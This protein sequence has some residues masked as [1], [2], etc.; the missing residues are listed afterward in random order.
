MFKYFQTLIFLVSCHILVAQNGDKFLLLNGPNWEFRKSGDSIWLPAN[1]PGTVHTDLMTLGLIPDPFVGNNEEKVQ[2]VENEGW[3]YRTSFNLEQNDIENFNI[4]LILEGLDTY[5]DV[6]VNDCLVLKA[7]NMFRSFEIDVKKHLNSGKNRL[8]IHFY[9]ASKHGKGEALKLPYSLPSDERIFCRKAQY[10]FGW[11]WGPRLV[12]CG[13]W[14]PVKLRFVRFAYIEHLSYTQN[15]INDTLVQLNLIA[16][17]KSFERLNDIQLIVKIDSPAINKLNIVKTSLDTGRRRIST[18]ILLPNPRKWWCNGLGEPFMYSV[19]F[20]LFKAYQELDI[21]NINIGIRTLDLVREKDSLGE[22]F[23]FKLNGIKV[24]AKGANVIPF[25][26]FLPR[27]KEGTY[28]KMVQNAVDA[29]MNMLRVWGGGVYGEDEFYDACDKQGIMVWQDFMFANSMYPST[30]ILNEKVREE[31]KSQI[32]RLRNHPSLALWCGNNE[33]IEGWN[34]WGWQKQYGYSS[35]DSAEIY[36]NYL[37]F[38]EDVLPYYILKMDPLRAKN[39]WPS[40]PSIG[41]GRKESLLKGDVHYW[42]V[43]WG[44]QPFEMYEKKVGRFVSEYGFQS[45]PALSTFQKVITDS[46]L[47]LNSQEVKSHQKHPTGYQTIQTYME[48]DYKVPTLFEDYIYVSQ[49]LQARGMKIAIEAHRRNK[50]Y[51]MGTL[52]WQMN[53]CWP[54]T[55]WSSIDYYGNLKASHYQVKRSFAQSLLS[56]KDADTAIEVYS[57][58]DGRV[59]KI[60]VLTIEVMDFKGKMLWQRILNVAIKPDSGQKQ[61]ILSKSIFKNLDTSFVFVLAK[62]KEVNKTDSLQA[63]YFLVKPKNLLLQKPAFLL[64]KINANTYS[65]SS[66]QV[67][68]GVELS[69][70]YDKAFGLIF[71]DNYFDL[72]PGQVK[73]I[74]VKNKPQKLNFMKEVRWKSL[75]E[76][77][78]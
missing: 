32:I 62:F 63:H 31:V 54:V 6:Y 38:F 18:T 50:P 64:S 67:A 77:S 7:D 2:W 21:R 53:D 48:R 41:W 43:W 9:P 52:Y 33:I 24:F 69:V 37:R 10:Q 34:N 15:F 65:I 20:R 46:V 66:D 42:G 35:K 12:T 23:Y 56:F 5:A 57:V 22:S 25:D 14:K 28:R 11:D 44:M 71:D 73:L 17:V 68:V 76:V 45:M 39:Y 51:C 29:N 78:N 4:D 72:L 27:V 49:L 70:N 59:A 8:L 40:S 3:Q 13:I 36:N 30:I 58:N 1:V 19:Q 60:G 74:H 16:D 75:Y 47:Y 26:N 55:S 61:F